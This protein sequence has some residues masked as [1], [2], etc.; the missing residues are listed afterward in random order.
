[1]VSRARLSK[2]LLSFRGQFISP[3]NLAPLRAGLFHPRPGIADV[4]VRYRTLLLGGS[5]F[6]GSPDTVRKAGGRWRA[7][8]CA[9][10]GGPLRPIGS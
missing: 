4:N 8:L 1:M 5:Y 6:A 2:A 10:H 3:P 9:A 7:A